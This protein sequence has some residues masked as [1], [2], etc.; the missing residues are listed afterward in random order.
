MNKNYLSI[1][2]IFISF[3][4]ELFYVLIRIKLVIKIFYRA[5]GLLTIFNI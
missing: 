1:Y 4:S 5:G 3:Q 2:A